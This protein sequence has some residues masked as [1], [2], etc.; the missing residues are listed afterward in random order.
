M[1]NS[2]QGSVH[3]GSLRPTFQWEA[4]QWSGIEQVLYII[5]ISEDSGFTATVTSGAT[6]STSFQLPSDLPVSRSAPVGAR[7]FWRV[8]AC[9][10]EACSG[11]SP[12]W[13]VNVGRTERDLNGDGYADVALTARGQATV[14]TT[15]GRLYIYLGGGGSFDTQADTVFRGG[16][17][18]WFRNVAAIGDLNGDG[19]ADLAARVTQTNGQMPR[20]LIYY[21]GKGSVLDS[22]PDHT[23]VVD[24]CAALSDWN[25][26]G[27]DDVL[28]SASNGTS[29]QLGGKE[30]TLVPEPF[31]VNT[32][33]RGVGDVNGDGFADL[34]YGLND[35][36]LFYFGGAERP[37]DH[38]TDG[39][40]TGAPSTLFGSSLAAAGDVNGDGF[41]DV[42]V[43]AP[44]DRT[45]APSGGRA[46]VYFGGRGSTFDA[47]PDGI[48]DGAA[49]ERL[50]YTVA[51]FGDLN[52]DGYDDFGIRTL[53]DFQ[54]RLYVYYGT[55]GSTVDSSLRTKLEGEPGKTSMFG[56]NSLG[57]DVNGDGFDDLWVGAPLY[58]T[59][60]AYSVGR[61]YI[62]L[63]ALGATLEPLPDATLDQGEGDEA[64]FGHLS[65]SSTDWTL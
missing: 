12:V 58:S 25:G 37:F 19:F 10:G 39:R 16:G 61:A 28:L 7:Y 33:A 45:K 20:V 46:F 62:F 13:Y 27:F 3:H 55:Q 49:D 52:G 22:T 35:E 60:T 30:M 2:Y 21:G 64:V 57:G 14:S 47:T 5:Q 18:T 1:N 53:F 26:D 41:A 63:G 65:M 36:V 34:S 31:A 17:T 23:L 59:Q 8:K 44:A 11:F 50:G 56:S 38:K 51:G 48:F 43:G 29:I 6:T 32:S 4:S 9:A 54:G 42:L 24:S 40:L 15:S